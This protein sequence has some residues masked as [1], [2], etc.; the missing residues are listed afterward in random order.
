ML[1]TVERLPGQAAAE[2]ANSLCA[3]ILTHSGLV[4]KPIRTVTWMGACKLACFCG[5]VEAQ[6]PHVM[7]VRTS[8]SLV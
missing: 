4:R 5:Y 3:T 6:G 2:S 1:M 8:T 7:T